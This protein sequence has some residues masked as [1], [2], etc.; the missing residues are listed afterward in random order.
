[1]GLSSLYVCLPTFP[2]LKPLFIVKTWYDQ[3]Y[4][5]LTKLDQKTDFD[6]YY[7]YLKHKCP[8]H[9][10]ETYENLD[11]WSIYEALLYNL[12][13]W[14][15]RRSLHCV[16][17]WGVGVGIFAFQHFQNRFYFYL[18]KLFLLLAPLRVNPPPPALTECFPKKFNFFWSPGTDLKWS[19]LI[20]KSKNRL[21]QIIKGYFMGKS[22]LSGVDPLPPLNWALR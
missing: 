15:Y 5:S 2:S 19:K 11:Y 14:S 7:I 4:I 13:R 8:I 18:W 3:S 1:M 20:I 10:F 21:K 9:T 17:V 22:K 16:C 12:L 6:E